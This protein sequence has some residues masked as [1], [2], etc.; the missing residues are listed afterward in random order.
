MV[1]SFGSFI[2]LMKGPPYLDLISGVC[3]LKI[4]G[5]GDVRTSQGC[6]AE[7]VRGTNGFG[8]KCVRWPRVLQLASTATQ[9]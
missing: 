6:T 2:S 9:Q 3:S 8:G 4:T 1:R 5:G 7:L